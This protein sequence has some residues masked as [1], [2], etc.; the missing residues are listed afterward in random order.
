[1]KEERSRTEGEGTEQTGREEK[2][3]KRWEF[4]YY[5]MV[6]KTAEWSEV[7]FS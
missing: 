2:K 7:D 3:K 6:E 5:K 4:I 1:M